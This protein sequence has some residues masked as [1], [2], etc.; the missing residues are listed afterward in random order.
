[1]LPKKY[2]LLLQVLWGIFVSLLMNSDW[3]FMYSGFLLVQLAFGVN[4]VKLPH[5]NNGICVLIPIFIIGLSFTPT[6]FIWVWVLHNL[7]FFDR[8]ILR[9]PNVFLKVTHSNYKNKLDD[10]FFNTLSHSLRIRNNNHW[11]ILSFDWVVGN[12]V[13][14]SWWPVIVY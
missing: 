8:T 7:H 1:M 9:Y 14:V 2:Q 6:L 4:R 12:I 13:S 10:S 5:N 11:M 3:L